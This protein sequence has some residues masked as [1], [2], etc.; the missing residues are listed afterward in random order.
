MPLKLTKVPQP[1]LNAIKELIWEYYNQTNGK[2]VTNPHGM[3]RA[4]IFRCKTM[5]ALI[6]MLDKWSGND[7]EH[8]EYLWEYVLE[9]LCKR[10]TIIPNKPTKLVMKRPKN[11]LSIITGNPDLDLPELKLESIQ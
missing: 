5:E 8:M 1:V 7:V 9:E 4:Y 10:Y 2:G 11:K 6:N 3:N